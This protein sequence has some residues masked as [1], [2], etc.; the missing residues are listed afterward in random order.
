MG[1]V[2]LE[3]EFG[4]GGTSDCC[5]GVLDVEMFLFFVRGGKF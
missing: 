5:A 1:Y 4:K 2:G 3:R